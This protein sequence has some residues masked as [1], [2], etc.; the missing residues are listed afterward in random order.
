MI[1]KDTK[2]YFA[3]APADLRKSYDGLAAVCAAQLEKDPAKGGMF[4]FLNKRANQVKILFRDTQGWC[5]LQKR[6][7]KG[8]FRAPQI[9]DGQ[10]C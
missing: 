5:V 10:V 4:V 6:I 1:P 7:D 9:E 2:V 8:R 3:K